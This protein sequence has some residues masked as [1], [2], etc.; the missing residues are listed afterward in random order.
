MKDHI[1]FAF[2]TAKNVWPGVEWENIEDE[3]N[4]FKYAC[5]ST[6]KRDVNLWAMIFA[7]LV[8]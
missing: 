3:A 1:C 4:T 5:L 8:F 7:R 2:E 6:N